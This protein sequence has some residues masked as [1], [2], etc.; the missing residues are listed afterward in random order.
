[1]KNQTKAIPEGFHSLTPQ[2][3]VKGASEAIEFY[4]KVFGAREI[5][6]LTAPDGKTII[7]ADL[8][9]GDSHLFLVDEN[10]GCQAQTFG[11]SPVTIHIYTEDVDG[12]FN[13]AVA[14]GA[15][16]RMPVS[17]MFWGDRYGAVTDPFGH[18]WS[19]AAHKEDLTPEEIH[20]RAEIAFSNRANA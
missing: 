7:H 15:Q 5:G 4:S 6:R 12:L 2:L 17:D 9:I 16:V 13:K 18:Q 19:L 1:M 3:V 20:K 14:A 8:V 11:A 10:T